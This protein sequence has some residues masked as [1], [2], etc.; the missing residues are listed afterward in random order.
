MN[1]PVTFGL[2]IRENEQY[3]FGNEDASFIACV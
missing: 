1:K 3:F 2:G